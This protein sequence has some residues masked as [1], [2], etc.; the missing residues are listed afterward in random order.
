MDKRITEIKKGP[1]NVYPIGASASNI[2]LNDGSILEEALGNINL[3]ENGSIIDQ[4]H[5]MA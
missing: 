3:A 4:I 1:S 2:T 5:N